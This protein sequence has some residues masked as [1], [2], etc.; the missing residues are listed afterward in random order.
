MRHLYEAKD[1]TVIEHAKGFERRRCNHHTL[2]KPL[3][4]LECLSEVVD[5]KSTLVNKHRYVVASQNPKVRVMLRRIPGV[6]LVYIN[7][8]V[9]IL[10]P[11][12]TATED[13]RDKEERAKL[14]EGIKGRRGTTES[15][16]RKRDDEN[17]DV[18]GQR[19]LDTISTP[20]A[21]K[22]PEKKRRKGEKGPNPLSVKKPKPRSDEASKPKR[23]PSNTKVIPDNTQI[24]KATGIA[25]VESEETKRKR[26]R[27]HKSR[28]TTGPA[29]AELVEES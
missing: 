27:K 26:K 3:T 12:A 13:V 28:E 9:M 2:E 23:A 15:A 7:R 29:D 14:R 22:R 18:N 10:E 19:T 25:D 21:P 11:M 8:S 24:S 17:E 1:E 6:P 5:P 20:D 4:A 16:K